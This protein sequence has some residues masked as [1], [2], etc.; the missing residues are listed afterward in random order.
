[1]SKLTA[2]LQKNQKK[3]KIGALA[4]LFLFVLLLPV[5]SS[6][7]YFLFLM[8]QVFINIIIVMGLN[9]ITGLVGQMHFGTGAIFS[10]G[11]YTSAI[12]TT[13]LG[14]SPWVGL[15]CAIVMGVL[16]GFGLG[17]PG[18]KVR[19]VYLWLITLAFNQVVNLLERNLVDLTGGTQGIK[20][21]PYFSLFG[22][23]L[24]QN[25]D[26]FYLYFAF[27]ILIVYLSWRICHSR[28]GR[29]FRAIRDNEESMTANGVDTSHKKILAFVI[30]TTFACFAG[31]LYAHSYNYITPSAFSDLSTN[32][33]VMM[34]VGGIG[35]IPGC[36]VGALVITLL[37]EYM[38]GLQQYYWLIFSFVTLLM[39]IFMP[40]GLISVITGD[41]EDSV[42]GRLRVRMGKGGNRN[43]RSRLTD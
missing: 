33:L 41:L 13:R 15:L 17:Y 14:V 24:S 1:M 9:I 32:Y 31:A 20:S 42:L 6:S 25:S 5:L 8:L 3:M 27:T 21:I 28:F 34:M 23:E 40:K 18:L 29:S 43:G 39:T 11:A 2:Y 7:N 16:I 30:S 12:V 35:S 10:L 37:P 4:A 38:R 19:G 36:I 22:K 26:M